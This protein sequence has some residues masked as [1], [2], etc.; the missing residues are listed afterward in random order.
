MEFEILP[1][2]IFLHLCADVPVDGV[3]SLVSASRALTRMYDNDEFYEHLALM[4]FTR[5]FWDR[6][7]LRT[8]QLPCATV[9]MELLRIERFQR[10]LETMPGCKRWRER[11]FFG[12]WDAAEA[13]RK[14]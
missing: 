13:H 3:M 2:D 1:P 14:T 6:A 7:A 8:T 10:A 9:K 11:E 5:E 4:Y 12:Y